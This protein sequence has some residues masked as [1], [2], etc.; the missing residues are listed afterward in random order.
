M[1]G[2]TNIYQYKYGPEGNR[3]SVIAYWYFDNQP[4]YEGYLPTGYV[5]DPRGFSLETTHRV[6]RLINR[7]YSI[8]SQEMYPPV[9]YNDAK[10]PVKISTNSNVDLFF[11]TLSY[12][13]VDVTYERNN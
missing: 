2:R 9:E 5:Y 8:N 12:L 4:E 10:L 6:W 1:A 13:D 7:D 11:A 3:D